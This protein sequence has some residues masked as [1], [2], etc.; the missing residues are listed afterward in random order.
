MNL[1]KELMGGRRPIPIVRWKPDPR[2]KYRHQFF[3]WLFFARDPE[4][5]LRYGDGAGAPL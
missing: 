2:T 5:W 4:P 3:L 1:L